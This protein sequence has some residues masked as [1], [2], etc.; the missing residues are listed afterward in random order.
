MK[1]IRTYALAALALGVPALAPTFGLVP[2]EVVL[3]WLLASVAVQ[4]VAMAVLGRPAP[5]TVT[6]S[7]R[8]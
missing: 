8:W 4:V 1:K 5:R 2:Q 6:S 7:A 3:P